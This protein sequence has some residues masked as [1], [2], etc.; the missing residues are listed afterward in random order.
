VSTNPEA[1]LY[2]GFPI[3]EEMPDG[4][5]Y[6]DA[7][8]KW[9]E[10]HRP[11]EPDDRSDYRTPEWDEW[12]A[13]LQEWKKSPE[14]VEV[15]WSGAENCECY[16]VHAYGLLISVEWGEQIEVNLASP[17]PEWDEQIRRFCESCGLEF[18][19]PKWYLAARYF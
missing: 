13:R 16:Y 1:L 6:F 14:Y 7:S 12:R 17:G 19:Q 11:K 5:D 2:Y 9:E 18:N 3:G 4:I 10:A 8:Q 15:G